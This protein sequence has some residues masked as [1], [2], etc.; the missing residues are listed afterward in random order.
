MARGHKQII[1]FVPE[2]RK[3]RH[4]RDGAQVIEPEILEHLKEKRLLAYTPSRR[5]NGKFIASHDDR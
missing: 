4:Q 3:Y 1:A 2:W 5:L